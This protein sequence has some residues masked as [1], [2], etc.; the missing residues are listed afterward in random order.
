MTRVNLSYVSYHEILAHLKSYIETPVACGVIQSK[1]EAERLI[2][3]QANIEGGNLYG[4][5]KLSQRGHGDFVHVTGVLMG[6]ESAGAYE[7]SI[8]PNTGYC[9]CSKLFPDF[10]QLTTLISFRQIFFF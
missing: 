1:E 10:F 5:I 2:S 6:L 7:I 4:Q 3:V 8:R 9:N